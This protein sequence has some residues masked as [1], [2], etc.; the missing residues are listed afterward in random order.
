MK[1]VITLIAAITIALTSLTWL[2]AA[3]LK[4]TV[5]KMEGTM[6]TMDCSKKASQVMVGDK[7]KVKT[8]KKTA[9]E[10]C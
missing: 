5:T 4:C 2:Q 3:T 9:I 10:G 6:I 7:L 8:A 1:R